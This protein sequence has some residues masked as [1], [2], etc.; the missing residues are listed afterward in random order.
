MTDKAMGPLMT[1]SSC[2]PKTDQGS[3]GKWM[4]LYVDF[5]VPG[6]KLFM[7]SKQQYNSSFISYT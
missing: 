3:I 5:W 4:N 6:V 1:K 2:R 7:L